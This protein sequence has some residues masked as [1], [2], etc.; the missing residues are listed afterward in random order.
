MCVDKP[1]TL[2][3]IE[4]A[5]G[6]SKL[7]SNA[8]LF[9]LSFPLWLFDKCSGQ[10]VLYFKIN[11][12]SLTGILQGNLIYSG[13]GILSGFFS[14]FP[15]TSFIGFRIVVT[16]LLRRKGENQSKRRR[17]KLDFKVWEVPV[18]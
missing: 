14:S 16:S 15:P 3:T 17:S 8:V 13:A 6:V 18:K 4:R 5:N 10:S 2:E 7:E 1:T 12:V 9:A 11:I